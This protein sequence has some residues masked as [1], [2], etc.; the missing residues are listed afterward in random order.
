MGV[1]GIESECAQK[2][3]LYETKMSLNAILAGLCSSLLSPLRSIAVCLF[4]VFFPPFS[5][6]FLHDYIMDIASFS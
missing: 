3:D 5:S 2:I 6:S 4:I 1:L